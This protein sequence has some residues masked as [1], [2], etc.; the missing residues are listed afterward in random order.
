MI[1]TIHSFIPLLN[2]M[3]SSTF[4]LWN[5]E[6]NIKHTITFAIFIKLSPLFLNIEFLCFHKW[7]EQNN[8]LFNSIIIK[9]SWWY[10]NIEIE[11]L[12][13]YEEREKQMN[14]WVLEAIEVLNCGCYSVIPNHFEWNEQQHE[15]GEDEH[16][17]CK[18]QLW[19]DVWLFFPKI[20]LLIFVWKE[21][22]RKGMIEWKW[23]WGE[24]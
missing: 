22:E 2:S 1:I 12:S 10:L 3:F 18:C 21:R 8:G 20:V 23:K 9:H 7:N 6:N 15:K 16:L 24:I 14:W 11:E 5:D 13:E 4:Q 17:N 19:C